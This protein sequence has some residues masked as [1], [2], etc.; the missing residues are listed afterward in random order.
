MTPE[1]LVTVARFA[2]PDHAAGGKGSRS[3]LIIAG[4]RLSG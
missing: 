2:T 1:P 3:Q 4:G